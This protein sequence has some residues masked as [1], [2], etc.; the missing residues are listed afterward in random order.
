MLIS[1]YY[2][3]ILRLPYPEQDKHD[4]KEGIAVVLS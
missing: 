4:D 1:F 3:Q 2:M